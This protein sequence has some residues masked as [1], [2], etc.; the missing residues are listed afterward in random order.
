M[1]RCNPFHVQQGEPA[2]RGTIEINHLLL[3]TL[4]KAQFYIQNNEPGPVFDDPHQV[5]RTPHIIIYLYTVKSGSVLFVVQVLAIT[6]LAWSEPM[7]HPKPE[8]TNQKK[9]PDDIER[10][11]HKLIWSS[12][13]RVRADDE[14]FGAPKA[15]HNIVQINVKGENRTS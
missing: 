5:S 10:L 11:T 14:G 7:F 6:N 8:A 1:T 2:F 12:D 4:F 13:H 15:L 9:D 3:K